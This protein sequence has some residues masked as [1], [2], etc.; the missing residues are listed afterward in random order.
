M[1]RG[2]PGKRNARP[3]RHSK[4][5]ARALFLYPAAHDGFADCSCLASREISGN[6]VE[7]LESYWLVGE[8]SFFLQIFRSMVRHGK[9]RACC[10]SGSL[11]VAQPGGLSIAAQLR[12][13]SRW[14]FGLHFRLRVYLDSIYQEPGNRSSPCTSAP[15]VLGMRKN[16]PPTLEL[17]LLLRNAPRRIGAKSR[18]GL[19][20]L[21]FVG[22]RTGSKAGRRSRRYGRRTGAREDVIEAVLC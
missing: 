6:R 17:L 5:F 16:L 15:R 22:L 7:H 8:R 13:F 11:L 1:V 4:L 19:R 12:A 9:A 20:R 14:R 2:L 18:D 10:G 3:F 21:L